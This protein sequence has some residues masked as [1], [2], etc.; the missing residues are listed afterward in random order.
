[1]DAPDSPTLLDRAVGHLWRWGALMLVS[2][3]LLGVSA[4]AL[5]QYD[6]S[7][8]LLKN[9]LEPDNRMDALGYGAK[10]IVAVI[11]VYIAAWLA[12][13]AKNRSLG[14]FEA[15][16][17]FSRVWF[18]SLGTPLVVTL[19]LGNF[20]KDDS[21]LAIFFI[22]IAMGLVMAMVHLQPFE[23]P[24]EPPPSPPALP[25][26]H[27]DR[28]FAITALLCIGYGAFMTR[29]ALLEHWSI[30]THAYD[31]GI[32]D[33]VMWNTIQGDWLGCSLC[34][35]G[36]HASGHY[37]PILIAMSPLYRVWP[38]PET[39]LVFQA[40]WLA[41]SGLPLYLIA[42]RALP[43]ARGYCV[44]LVGMF[45]LHPGLHGVNL[46]DFHSL[47]LCVPLVLWMVHCIDA[48]AK[49][50]FPLPFAL[51]LL[52]REDMPLIACFIGAYAILRRRPVW[53]LLIILAS[54]A[55]LIAIKKYAMPDSS[56]LMQQS[57]DAASHIYYYEDM[58]PYP[59]EGMR[60]LVVSTFSNP[61][62]ATKV[63]F[64]NAEKNFYIMGLLLP[65]LFLPLFGGNKRV[66]MLY[67][68]AFIGL[69][70]RPAVYSFHFQYSAVILPFLFAAVPDATNRVTGW[71]ARNNVVKSEARLRRTMMF[72]MI[73]AT[74]LLSARFG[75]FVPN[76]TFRGGWNRLNRAIGAEGL[77][78]YEAVQA[79]AEQIPPDA[80]VCASSALVPH[81][82]GRAEVYLFPKL[83][84]ADYV[85]LNVPA[86]EKKK[87]NRSKIRSIRRKYETV[88]QHE[89]V[90]LFRRTA[91]KPGDRKRRSEGE[92]EHVANPELET[93][94][95]LRAAEQDD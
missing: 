37:D 9:D 30:A 95:R 72:G 87:R 50:W 64:L 78:H 38:R 76:K 21:L 83:K 61:A 4:Y 60:G 19:F 74:V 25:P 66:L 20:K 77:E 41:M 75:A 28:A 42:R 46:Y 1:M 22:A 90:E 73:T 26:W 69:V 34:K 12:Q 79:M 18:I 45:F 67:G 89:G 31:L 16:T 44:V 82:S 62:F 24:A 71:A 88:A 3:W 2:G 14:A 7:D 32:Y 51:M 40:W 27:R 10:G 84:F 53:G 52:V 70:S 6:L 85:L 29:L 56:L 36:N 39:L 33:N 58:I 35:G 17:K 54:A 5:V 43:Q 63:I 57:K 86:L 94:R 49:W 59:E 8:Y 92:A 68:L 13:R 81:V 80:V 15:F 65:V 23:D 93:S 11:F 47:A 48:G 55:Y 91:P